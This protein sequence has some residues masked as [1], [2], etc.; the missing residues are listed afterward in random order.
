MFINVW[1]SE[2]HAHLTEFIVNI[3]TLQSTIQELNIDHVCFI[4]DLNAHP[5]RNFYDELLAFCRPIGLHI[6]NVG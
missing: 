3:G 2:M 6:L 5:T 4:E 1:P